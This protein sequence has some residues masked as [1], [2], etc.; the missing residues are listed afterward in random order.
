M[1]DHP[2]YRAW[3]GYA[4]EQICLDH[5]AQIKKSLGIS[6]I[7]ST[8]S[9]WTS[10]DT[11]PGAQIDLIIDRRDQTIT[12]CEAKF[13]TDEYSISKSYAAA[14]RNK[15]GAF[16]RETKTKKAVLL[17]MIT[18]FGVKQNAYS[19]SVMQNSIT[20]DDLFEAL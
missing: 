1:I 12:I 8:A 6:G 9:S 11:E 14:L 16:K 18:T 17:A 10:S 13:S 4:F 5:I 19:G 7:R 3:T 2:S 15:V 20:M